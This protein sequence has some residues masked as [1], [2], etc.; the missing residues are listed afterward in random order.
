MS[1][2]EWV[3]IRK[4]KLVL[5]CKILYQN[6]PRKTEDNNK[7][8]RLGW[9]ITQMILLITLLIQ[10]FSRITSVK[11]EKRDNSFLPIRSYTSDVHFKSPDLR[12][13]HN[14]SNRGAKLK[15]LQRV[16]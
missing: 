7:S 5:S 10:M 9:P 6:V 11:C 1:N 14:P 16:H 8:R 12:D 3:R 2:N 13:F 4:Y 15:I